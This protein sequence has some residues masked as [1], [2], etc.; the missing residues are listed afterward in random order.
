[1]TYVIFQQHGSHLRST[2]HSHRPDH[3]NPSPERAVTLLRERQ[4]GIHA[5][6]KP[7][8]HRPSPTHTSPTVRQRCLPEMRSQLR[9][10]HPTRNTHSYQRVQAERGSH[11]GTPG[12]RH[13]PPPLPGNDETGRETTRQLPE[14]LKNPTFDILKQALD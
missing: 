2:R 3:T 11:D 9:Q 8:H 13:N 10:P 1:M 14:P 7:A 4:P 5:T 6:P 12:S